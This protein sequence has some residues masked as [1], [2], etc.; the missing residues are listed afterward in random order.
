MGE[1]LLSGQL[2]KQVE[3]FTYLGSIFQRN[4]H[5]DA[6]VTHRVRAWWSKWRQA[7]GV[8]GDKWVLI[9]VKSKFYRTVVRP[10]MLYGMECW[11]APEMA[12]QLALTSGKVVTPQTVRNQLHKAGYK[13]RTARK[14]LFISGKKNRT[15]RLEFANA[16][17]NKPLEFWNNVLFT[18]ES[19][20]N[21][22]DQMAENLFGENP[23]QLLTSRI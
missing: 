1:V 7:S 11:A 16:N 14:K 2:V 3:E 18:D 15:K 21:F 20:F 19:K 8:L 6:D 17:V 13:A 4:G 23:T 22:L 12:K 9:K 5:I 10:T